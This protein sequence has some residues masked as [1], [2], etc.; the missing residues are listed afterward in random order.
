VSAGWANLGLAVSGASV[1]P[2]INGKVGAPVSVRKSTAG[3]VALVSGYH[4]AL[5][6]NFTLTAQP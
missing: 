1:T 6:D 2:I 5:Y 4:I 3:M